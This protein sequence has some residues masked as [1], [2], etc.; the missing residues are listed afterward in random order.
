MK[1]KLNNKISLLGVL[2]VV[3]T[4]AIGVFALN[5]FKNQHSNVAGNLSNKITVR[6]Q[7]DSIYKKFFQGTKEI[8]LTKTNTIIHTKKID[9]QKN[10]FSHTTLDTLFHR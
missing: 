9:T 1:R 6:F 3:F 10:S 7:K 8:D 5:E 4:I 2:S